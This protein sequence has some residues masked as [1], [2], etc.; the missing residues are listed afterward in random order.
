MTIT[1]IA[2]ATLLAAFAWAQISASHARR[3]LRN[4]RRSAW[5]RGGKGRLERYTETD[6][7]TRAK[8]DAGLLN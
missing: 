3:D 6:A 5:V 1:I 7:D 4:L 8:A 2:A